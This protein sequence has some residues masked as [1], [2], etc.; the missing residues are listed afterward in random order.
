MD[1]EVV[2][3]QLTSAERSLLLRYGYPFERIKHALKACS[4][5]DAIELV[6]MDRL[7]LERLIGDL[8]Y[9]INH[10]EAGALQ[11]R[12]NDLCDRLEAAE[13]HGDGMLGEF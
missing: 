13:R 4:K 12:L 5:S 6:P 10:M 7:E 2:E 9:S 11:N 1:R 8:S 3:I